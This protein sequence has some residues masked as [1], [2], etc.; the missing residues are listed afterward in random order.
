M[1]SQFN[2]NNVTQ[3]TLT[4]DRLLKHSNTVDS[5]KI[6]LGFIGH[7]HA[8]LLRKHLSSTDSSHSELADLVQIIAN[9]LNGSLDTQLGA[10]TNDDKAILY[11]K[12]TEEIT[13]CT[14]GFYNRCA[15]IVQWFSRPQDFFELLQLVRESL[16]SNIA[17]KLTQD[18]HEVNQVFLVA[19]TLGFGVRVRNKQDT[20]R[21][22]P[23]DTIRSKITEEFNCDFTPL[24]LPYLICE[25]FISIISTDYNGRKAHGV[26][27][28]AGEMERIAKLIER[29]FSTGAKRNASEY[30]I[31][32][33][34][35]LLA[36]LDWALIRRLIFIK[37][38]DT[39]C[40]Q[41]RFRQAFVALDKVDAH[42]NPTTI[43]EHIQYI[44]ST[45]QEVITLLT[46]F[47]KETLDILASALKHHSPD[48]FFDRQILCEHFNTLDCS[49]KNI[50]F[51]VLACLLLKDF[52]WLHLQGFDLRGIN[53]E[54]VNLQGVCLNQVKL[55]GMQVRQLYQAGRLNFSGADLRETDLREADLREADL[56]CANLQNADLREANLDRT[57]LRETNF[58][59]AD[60]REASFQSAWRLRDAFLHRARLS[61]NQVIQLHQAGL[62][63]FS[64]IDLRGADLREANLQGLNLR[65][66]KLHNAD[67]GDVNFCFLSSFLTDNDPDYYACINQMGLGDQAVALLLERHRD[68]FESSAFWSKKI[69]ANVQ[70]SLSDIVEHAKG[71]HIRRA[72]F[73][74]TNDGSGTKKL[75][76]DYYGLSV[77]QNTEARDIVPVFL[78]RLHSSIVIYK[79]G[80]S[81]CN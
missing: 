6:L 19:S 62:N 51:P 72:V 36:D 2:F 14:P 46:Y 17:A 60:L 44:A 7:E 24:H 10:M 18:V 5:R 49:S 40:F 81:C 45:R 70:I 4:N 8:N 75:L 77:T 47:K 35:Y 74:D 50:F 48:F 29:Y 27:Y 80:W 9:R 31:L 38:C 65:D 15:E 43:I 54:Y 23:M 32:Q 30:F 71:K 59:Y 21:F 20:Y 55:D 39:G 69:K 3:F 34:D 42:T 66:A 13:N 63:D 78:T 68:F 41:E 25:Q 1:R 73:F 22:W 67:L 79:K 37:L 58:Q 12:L 57:S 61:G 52:K 26:S 64:G 11:Y 33:D 76:R 56:T 28:N 53:L 16:V